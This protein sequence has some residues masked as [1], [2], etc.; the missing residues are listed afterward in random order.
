MKNATQTDFEALYEKNGRGVTCLWL[1]MAGTQEVRAMYAGRGPLL[2][3]NLGTFV[4]TGLKSPIRSPGA[5]LRQRVIPPWTNN[6]Q[7]IIRKGD[8][9]WEFV[10]A[11]A[12][13]WICNEPRLNTVYTPPWIR[14]CRSTSFAM[15][16]Q[17]LSVGSYPPRPNR[18]NRYPPHSLKVDFF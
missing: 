13:E 16:S 7:S 10:H 1:E 9:N 14:L 3:N 8:T 5:H 4:P 11:S 2:V 17:V 18:Q 12:R 6:P 15:L